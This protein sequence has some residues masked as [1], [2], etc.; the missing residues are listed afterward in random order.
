[1][2]T[3]HQKAEEM[4]RK[5]KSYKEI[6]RKLS[7][8]LSTLSNW[9]KNQDWSIAIRDK[10]ATEASFS[11]PEKLAL[12]VTSNKKRWAKWHK[13]CQQEAINEYPQLKNGPLFAAGLLL[14]WGEGD[15]KLENSVVRLSNTDPLMI[16]AFSNFLEH[17]GIPK[18]K[19]FVSLLLYPD[20]TDTV[21]K[22]FWSTSTNISLSQF[23]KSVYIIGRHPK[24]RLS[25]GV[26]TIL[27]HSRKLK[28][29]ITVW[30]DL[31]K[32]ELIRIP[33]KK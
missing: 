19:I 29:K 3:D 30:L 9:F 27:V 18:E 6:G 31:Y 24:K 4:R 25:Y 33:L 12:M 22:N 10:L 11:S 1:M 13:E 21:S 23:K 15:K 7:I 20:L 32:L 26:C 28:E 2:R 5:G 8:P 17:V 16:R 14:Y